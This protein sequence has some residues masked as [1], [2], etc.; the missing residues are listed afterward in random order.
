VTRSYIPMLQSTR[1]VEIWGSQEVRGDREE[2]SRQTKEGRM[3]PREEV[4]MIGG[5]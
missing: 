4:S 3:G 5:Q 2:A 1:A